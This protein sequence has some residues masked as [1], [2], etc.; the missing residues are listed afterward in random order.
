MKKRVI[1]LLLVIVMLVGMIPSFGITSGASSSV[2]ST[3]RT[4][5][6]QAILSS[7]ELSVYKQGVTQKIANDGYIGIPVEVTVYYD[8]ATH[9]AAKTGYWG[10]PVI[11]YVVN[12]MAERVGTK[13]DEQ[14]ILSMVERGYAV[15]V[16][17]YLNSA[18]AVSPALEWSAQLLRSNLKSGTYFSD[19]TVFPAGTYYENH[20]VPAG[21]DISLNNV[22]YE[23][24]KHGADG[25]L[26]R[27]VETWN[28][29]FRSCHPDVIIKWVDG[30]GNRKSTQKGWDG[31]SPVWYADAAGKTV[32]NENGQYIK[33]NHTWA[34]RIEDCVKKDGSP[35]DFN[36]YM[37]IVYPTNPKNE[38]PVMVLSGSSEHL[39]SGYANTERPHTIGFA[40]NGYAI[41][42]YDFEYVPMARNDHYGYFAG[43]AS[44]GVSTINGTFALGVYSM[45]NYN[46]A[47]IRYLR[48]I[49]YT[50]PETYKFDDEAI[51]VMG[52]SKGGNQTFL[53]SASLL[54][55]KTISDL[56]AGATLDDLREYVSRKA[57]HCMILRYL[58]VMDP[59]CQVTD[60]NGQAD[61]Y[62]TY[63]G[64]SRYEN[65]F[66]QDTDYDGYH[67]DGG[68]LQPWLTY[69]DEN[70]VIREIMSGV[71]LVYSSCSGTTAQEWEGISPVVTT[72]NFADSYGS[73][74]N[75]H[76]YLA[77]YLRLY[78]V[79]SLYL[80]LPIE[81][82]LLKGN[83]IET[84]VDAYVSYFKF[85]DY[86]LKGS[87][88]SVL[89]I[90]AAKGERNVDVTEGIVIK[91]LGEVEREEITKITI[92]DENG[93]VAVGEWVSS[94]GNTQWT[95][96]PKALN[97]GVRYTVTV[98]ANML[99][100]NGKAMGEAYSSYF[101]TKPETAE[102]YGM[103]A[104]VNASSVNGAYFSFTVPAQMPDNSNRLMLRFRVA[105]NAANIA[106]IYE[107]SSSNDT[108]GDLVGSI[109]LKGAG[110]YEYDVTDY[111]MSKSV[112]TKVF[113]CVK[114]EK[115]AGDIVTY[116]HDFD[117]MT[118]ITAYGLR[119]LVT[120]VEGENV[121]ALRHN[122]KY[123]INKYGVSAGYSGWYPTAWENKK[124]INNGNPVTE[125]DYGRTFTVTLRLLATA[126]RPIQIWFNDCTSQDLERMD[127]SY[128]RVNVIATEGE[129]MEIS[130]PYTVYE[131]DYGVS[132]QVKSIK[133]IEYFGGSDDKPVY[134]DKLTVTEHITDIEISEASL[135]YTSVG[136]GEYK[137]PSSDKAFEV[138]GKQYAT[139]AEAI[140]AAKNA[141]EHTVKL[142]SDY[143]F[144]SKKHASD[145]AALT[146]LG[147]V[148]V[149][150][151]GY[152]V[153]LTDA[154]MFTVSSEN[155][156]T[157]RI[158][159]CN[160]TIALSDQPIIMHTKANADGDG[161]VYEID[162]KNVCVDV[163]GG[164]ACKLIADFDTAKDRNISRLITFEN[165][166][167]DA[168]RKDLPR[169]MPICLF[170]NDGT[171]YKLVG[172][173]IRVD[174]L[175]RFN[176]YDDVRQL[177]FAKNGDGNYTEIKIADIYAL[178]AETTVMSDKGYAYYVAGEGVEGYKVYVLTSA[179]Y[180]TPYGIIP[181]D[182]SP[183]EY[184]FALFV[185]GELIGLY[186]SYSNGSDSM[187]DNALY[188]AFSY[189]RGEHNKEV[190]I[191]LRRDYDMSASEATDT[192]YK[193]LSQIG[194]T[195]VLH[196]GEYNI[197]L[198]DIPLLHCDCKYGWDKASNTTRIYDTKII[199]RGGTINSNK[200]S[201]INYSSLLCSTDAQKANYNKKKLMDVTFEGTVINSTV[202]IVKKTGN[203]NEQ[204]GALLTVNFDDCEINLSSVSSAITL[205]NAQDANKM[206][207]LAVS[208]NGGNI[209]AS[210]VEKITLLSGDAEDSLVFSTDK[211]GEY[212]TLT[213]PMDA[214][215]GSFGGLNDK[216]AFVEFG[217]GVS[218]GI[219]SVYTLAKSGNITKYGTIPN[220]Y[221]SIENYPFAVFSD[222]LF[223]DAFA[224]LIDNNDNDGYIYNG[225]KGVSS[226]FELARAITL[227]KSDCNVQILMR[228]N[229][230]CAS[231]ESSYNNLAHISG[232]FTLDL[233]G[234]TLTTVSGPLLMVTVKCAWSSALDK[235]VLVPS[236]INVKN[237]TFNTKQALVRVSTVVSDNYNA[238]TEDKVITYNFEDL[239]IIYGSA[240][241]SAL[242]AYTHADNKVP[243]KSVYVNI[244][245]NN[246]TIDI[247]ALGKVE[248]PLV[249]GVD[250]LGT[251]VNNVNVTINGGSLASG[252]AT[253]TFGNFDP[254]VGTNG[255][256]LKFG[257]YENS[258]MEIVSTSDVVPSIKLPTVNEGE[259]SYGRFSSG[260]VDNVT[261]Y[262]N[263][264]GEQTEY[265]VIPFDYDKYSYPFAVFK[266]GV[267]LG[268][269]AF[270]QRSN[271]D[272]ALYVARNQMVGSSY[273]NVTVQILLRSDYTTDTTK[274]EW[275]SNLAHFGG[276]VII[277]LNGY[278]FTA[279]G[280]PMFVAKAQTTGT[281]FTELTKFIV[282]NGTLTAGKYNI[283]N[284][285]T[286]V[287]SSRVD[288]YTGAK[289]FDFTFENVEFKITGSR[290][291]LQVTNS[292]NEFG[293]IFNLTLNNCTI[294][295]TGTNSS[296]SIFSC[297]S[298]DDTA[299]DNVVNLIIDGGSIAIKDTSKV[300]ILRADSVDTHLFGKG[301]DGKMT[302]LIL[303]EG[304]AVPD[305][306][307]DTVD[308]KMFF[309][310][311]VN[312]GEYVLSSCRHSYEGVIT[313]PTCIDKGYTTYTCS[314]CGSSY[315]CDYTDANSLHVDVAPKDHVCD[316]GCGTTG[317]GEHWDSDDNDHLC[318]YGCNGFADDGCYD[319]EPDGFCDECGV[320]MN[321]ACIGG[322]ATCIAKA[323]CEICGK[324]YG[325]LA[326]HAP[327]LD[328]GDCTTD[329][330]CSVC[331]EV[332]IEGAASHVGGSANCEDKAVCSVCGKEYG[333]FAEHI[334]ANGDEKCDV[335]GADMSS[336]PD[337][338]D[339][340]KPGDSEDPVDDNDG[341]GAGAIIAIVA[342][343]FVGV[344]GM[345]ALV[346][347]VIKK[348]NFADLFGGRNK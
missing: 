290:P 235:Y 132:S 340:E 222:G 215:L 137:A 3:K 272:S 237:G 161:K 186:S 286:E 176:I 130:I 321:H 171:E 236:I 120:N 95:F 248:V 144:S 129:W 39:A 185:D 220:E 83:D 11:L 246:C 169:Y 184:P 179:K 317:I 157:V 287:T 187:K 141:D 36:L 145:N 197:T 266:N 192:Y 155:K 61:K 163:V 110:Y 249:D 335:C 344:A 151:N 70:G 29:D 303:P 93:N 311:G 88:V 27:I 112:G 84:G 256:S 269:Y 261:L 121:T 10:T 57:T 116:V 104:S 243:T 63:D 111:V 7:V 238:V 297:S 336:D 13:T 19:A 166:R 284:A 180:S 119:T 148:K 89:Y 173:E 219:N 99:G 65:G 278:N 64:D 241:Y 147:T 270:W 316:Y 224:M 177:T 339:P 252:K 217:D 43:D 271:S 102:I 30:S 106:N 5:A 96:V 181:D 22:Y 105:N 150:L 346:W 325:K 160:G 240:T 211:Y 200:A 115:K 133:V 12:T 60:Q 326:P 253:V 333:E 23:I 183:E 34:K 37:H 100:A 275:Y 194:G 139:W 310:E 71:Q 227:G 214:P 158:E 90:D 282:K 108:T 331:G 208:L 35:I 298:D 295:A 114:A 85:C 17:D 172:G 196:L 280:R 245:V 2:S 69:T 231:T 337:V 20:V 178:P 207:D 260:K 66:T 195:L 167:I 209:T 50:Q 199:I 203:V 28:Y 56:G 265:G 62:Y 327:N 73:S 9:G 79:P 294:D 273:S 293:A 14:I 162:F 138:D 109:N 107:A 233:G 92:V 250:K 313:P 318:D 117:T 45:G 91:F 165:C 263:R 324:E 87:A 170:P 40:F 142:L 154:S 33:V 320:G 123:S 230:T 168:N 153:S 21:C 67:V 306:V 201:I 77:N 247:S 242:I 32:D 53:G 146:N 97:G 191:Y 135:V 232:E 48:Y 131:M 329:I 228:R 80:E 292:N 198:G 328:D 251:N 274:D 174:T 58:S 72:S 304:M 128:S 283:I 136:D 41:A 301:S 68:E 118:D 259:L 44:K 175:A 55:S 210:C 193:N 152:T 216:G 204:Y 124:L 277:D 31:S 345:F 127:Y 307:F 338:V 305:T 94:Y 225:N 189:I 49:S 6:M 202:P 244:N 101:Y 205:F 38:V 16:V 52:N 322:A 330:I 342:G 42:T 82:S 299:N 212:T 1:S 291:I 188:G 276:T 264:V 182:K 309:V 47:A 113:F 341:L 221:E 258:Y 314:S 323:R 332:A 122:L 51:G 206:N 229:Y 18:K 15:A 159:V 54:E 98:P 281:N 134:Y 75:T 254:Q 24:D 289:I 74:Y 26:E 257:K 190:Q 59:S 218:D 268:A 8:Y 300:T 223:I 343:V 126:S 308:G 255:D 226:A 262:V 288:S 312:D 46:T 239:N 78:D 334:D 156:T 164:D 267:L 86:Y 149:D 81:H 25:S 143:E 213:L 234:Y 315:I 319:N 103:S 279:D 347:F 4:D 348:K 140:T 285:N 302:V 76:N 125:A 296:V